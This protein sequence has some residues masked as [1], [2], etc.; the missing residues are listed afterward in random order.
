MKKTLAVS[1]L[2]CATTFCLCGCASDKEQQTANTSQPSPPAQPKSTQAPQDTSPREGRLKVGMS[3]DEVV[4]A[5][6]KPLG[7]A[8][9]SDGS[10]FW[11]YN[12]W[13][14]T[15]ALAQHSPVNP[16][17]LVLTVIFDTNNKVQRW[18]TTAMNAY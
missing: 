12:D 18:Y 7:T 1:L 9:E 11:T 8:V 6:G 2:V 13:A 15:P 16:K 5:I 17:V 4:R 10:Q 14:T 3:T